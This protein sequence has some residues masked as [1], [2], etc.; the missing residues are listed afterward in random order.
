[1]NKD[2]NPDYLPPKARELA[3]DIGLAATL[4]LVE[5]RGGVG[6]YVPTPE[7]LTHDHP[8]VEQIGWDA[9]LI[10]A[11]KYLGAYTEV[12]RCSSSLQAALRDQIVARRAAGES[13][14]SVA[15]DVGIWERSVRRICTA[16]RARDD[17][18]GDLFE[19]G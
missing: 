16:A 12:P 11:K 17:S 7:R 5:W 8:L 14:A 18:Q 2:I 10:L 19:E 3:A 4:R 13:A 6:I 15:L 1:M 9:A